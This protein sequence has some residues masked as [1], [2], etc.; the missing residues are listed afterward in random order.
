MARVV[1]RSANLLYLL[2]VFVFL[3]LICAALAAVFYTQNEDS[4]KALAKADSE[5]K[6]AVK[7]QGDYKDSFKDIAGLVTDNRENGPEATKILIEQAVPS[8]VN[9]LAVIRESQQAGDTDKKTAKDLTDQLEAAKVAA[10][11]KDKSTED[12]LKKDAEAKDDL[13]KK[14]KETQDQFEA[15]H[16][17]YLADVADLQKQNNLKRSEQ[18]LTIAKQNQTIQED[19]LSVQKKDQ[20]I[21]DLQQR[22]DEI[23]KRGTSTTEGSVA[24]IKGHVM[25]VVPDQHMCYID[26]GSR[27]RVSPG[28]TFSVYA[29]S[30]IPVESGKGK[31]T[32]TVV[33]TKENTAECRITM[34]DKDDAIAA[35]DPIGNVAYDPL[36]TYTFAV[37]GQFDLTGH[38]T[39][40]AEGASEVKSIITHAGGKVSDE[41]GIRTDFIIMGSEPAKP[42]KPAESAPAPVQKVYEEQVKGYEHYQDVKRQAQVMKIPILN[43][44]RF[45]ALV[46]YT[47]GKELVRQ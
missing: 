19:I 36:R 15:A 18:D 29:K 44:N 23:N 40:G 4:Q 46:G 17:K 34:Q 27:D 1:Q 35:N 21:A 10:A 28:M 11:A 20:R 25:Q 2:V 8:H 39:P 7:S 12:L 5:K 22:L 3:F 47:A 45:L 13:A 33:S 30:G 37:E 14:L 9:L 42:S 38:G 32:V 26:L 43:T 24:R 31:A 41:V 6:E 16:Q